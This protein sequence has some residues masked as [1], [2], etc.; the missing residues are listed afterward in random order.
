[1][2]ELAFEAEGKELFSREPITPPDGA[3]TAENPILVKSGNADRVVG[4]EDPDCHQL[5]WFVLKE[6][7]NHYLPALK[8]FF[9]LDR[10]HLPTPGAPEGGAH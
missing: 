4:Y 9:K 2:E 8:L 5:H 1:M 3:G 10:D 6:G 7:P